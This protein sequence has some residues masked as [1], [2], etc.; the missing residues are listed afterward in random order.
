MKGPGSRFPR[1]GPRIQL[2]RLSA[3][4]LEPFQAY[5]HDPDVGRFQG[6]TPW[7]D[8]Q[9]LAFLQ[10]MEKASLFRPGTWCQIGIAD[11]VSERLIG[12]I[13]I[14]LDEKQNEAEIGFTL[15]AKSQGRG[16]G[17][18]AVRAAI[19]WAFEMTEILRVVSVTDSRNH[20]A[21]KLLER[22]GMQRF[23]TVKNVFKGQ[24]CTEHLYRLN[25]S[26]GL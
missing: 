6:W 11:R 18:E 2:R 16:L 8:E 26:E 12:D 24:P 4:D 13:G 3:K 10:E 14:H 23:R 25:R 21:I 22:I 17:T 5:R 20:S 7:P 19:D 1:T 9:A 15:Q